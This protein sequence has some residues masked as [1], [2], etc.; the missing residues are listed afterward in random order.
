MGVTSPLELVAQFSRGILSWVKLFTEL[1]IVKSILKTH[2]YKNI[3]SESKF[4]QLFHLRYRA[5]QWLGIT[6]ILSF[7]QLFAGSDLALFVHRIPRFPGFQL[8]VAESSRGRSPAWVRPAPNSPVRGFPAPP[9][10]EPL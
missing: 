10:P 5:I 1:S 9:R 4:E 2:S 6:P 7:Y 8:C 3:Y